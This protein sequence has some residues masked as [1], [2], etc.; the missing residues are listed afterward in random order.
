MT[1]SVIGQHCTIGAGAIISHS[2]IFDNTV[3]GAG[4]VV[5]RSIIGSDV[6]I[7][8]R[9]SVEQGCLVGDGVI[10]GRNAKLRSFERLSVK[11]DSQDDESDED[12]EE[13]EAESLEGKNSLLFYAYI[14]TVIY[15]ASSYTWS[16]FECENLA[17]RQAKG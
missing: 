13:E 4:V 6:H 17:P 2:Y 5:E 15:R 7:G 12:S 9:S 16:K 8:D 3:I 11:M 1:A 10:L 14:F